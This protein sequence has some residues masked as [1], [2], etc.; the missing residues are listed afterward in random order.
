MWQKKKRALF[1]PYA[2]YSLTLAKLPIPHAERYSSHGLRRGDAQELQSTGCQW[3]TVASIG[4]WRT[5]SFKGYV[6]L[7]N[8]V[9]R[10]LPE[11]LAEDLNL[12]SDGDEFVE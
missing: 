11:L 4:D 8:Q 2:L 3:A 6:D 1:P 7:T 12:D 9:I 5:L 10:D